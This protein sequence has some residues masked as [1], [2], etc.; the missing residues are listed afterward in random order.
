MLAR[1][2]SGYLGRVRVG[3]WTIGVASML[4]ATACG[5]IGFD[6]AAGDSNPSGFCATHAPVAFCSDFDDGAGTVS[7]DPPQADFGTLSVVGGGRSPPFGLD[8]APFHLIRG[9]VAAPLVSPLIGRYG[10]RCNGALT[11]LIETCVPSPSNLT[12]VLRASIVNRS[13]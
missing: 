2:A 3:T 8:R 13:S 4:V 7:W 12:E 10:S 5:R 6:A 1:T 9:E 11:A